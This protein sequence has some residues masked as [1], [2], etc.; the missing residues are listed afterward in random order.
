MLIANRTTTTT[1]HQRSCGSR[2]RAKTL[3]RSG[4]ALAHSHVLLAT[5]TISMLSRRH[6]RF[7]CVYVCVFVG[8]QTDIYYTYCYTSFNTNYIICS[9]WRLGFVASER[10]H[11]TSEVTAPRAASVIRKLQQNH[12]QTNTPVARHSHARIVVLARRRRRRRRS[13]TIPL[14]RGTCTTSA[15][16][17]CANRLPRSCGHHIYVHT[18]L[19]MKTNNEHSHVLHNQTLVSFT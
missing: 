9:R 8:T 18:H 4:G 13:S 3:S 17:V 5:Q 10:L 14:I 1:Q 11:A 2:A 7:V 6:T 16:R 19:K 12:T 15:Q